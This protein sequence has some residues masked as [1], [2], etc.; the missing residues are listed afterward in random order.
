MIDGIRRENIRVLIS[1]DFLTWRFHDSILA[2]FL[3]ILLRVFLRSFKQRKLT[4][5]LM[6]SSADEFNQTSNLL[7]CL[8]GSTPRKGRIAFGN[9]TIETYLNR[10]QTDLS[11]GLYSGVRG[12]SLKWEV[13]ILRPAEDSV[14]Q[15]LRLLYDCVCATQKAKFVVF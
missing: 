9:A 8:L 13:E 14:F 15:N 10:K 6:A 3:I 12:D 2:S 7:L 4:N 1:F 5:L 11:H